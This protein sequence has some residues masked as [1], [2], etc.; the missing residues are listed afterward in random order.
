VALEFGSFQNVQDKLYAINIGAAHAYI[1]WPGGLKH[2]LKRL[3]MA[4][5]DPQIGLGDQKTDDEAKNGL[6]FAFFTYQI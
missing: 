3:K 5:I 4:E 1:H 2:L 6:N